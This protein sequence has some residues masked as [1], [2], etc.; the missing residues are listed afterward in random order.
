[1]A[2]DERKRFAG[3]APRDQRFE[4]A[5]IGGRCGVAQ[6]G[7]LGGPE[8]MREQE[9]SFQPGVVDAGAPQAFS[10]EADGGAD[11]GDQAACGDACRACARKSRRFS[12]LASTESWRSGVLS[13]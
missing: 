3:L 4:R 1:M 10:G 6:Q 13:R 8:S 5:G 9:T 11:G 12:A 2:E 7:L